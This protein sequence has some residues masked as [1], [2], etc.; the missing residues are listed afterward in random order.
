MTEKEMLNA[1]SLE[2][3][4]LKAAVR[5]LAS[6]NH[7]LKTRLFELTMRE[8]F[9]CSQCGRKLVK[10]GDACPACN[11]MVAEESRRRHAK[12][13]ANVRAKKEFQEE[14]PKEQALRLISGVLDRK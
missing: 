11:P 14:Q 1:K 13:Q 3:S 2:C 6:A 10:T 8:A 9:F 7:V 5:D 12:A 4:E